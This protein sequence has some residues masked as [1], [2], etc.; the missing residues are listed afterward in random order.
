M[1][2]YKIGSKGDE[3]K[4]I[5]ERLKELNYYKGPIDGIFGGGTEAAVRVFQKWKKIGVDGRI[6]P[7]TWNVL[8]EE[9]ISEPAIFSEP[10]DYKCLALT[11]SFETGKGI[12]EC[13]AGLT[14]DFD[15]QGIS[16]GVLHMPMG[17]IKQR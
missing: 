16:V 13:F 17:F 7:I 6:G 8:F 5:Q 11:G 10:I 12:P 1:A 3:V 4:R 2:I 9:E 15:G 14:G